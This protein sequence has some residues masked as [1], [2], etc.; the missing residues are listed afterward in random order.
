MKDGAA[1]AALAVLAS[2]PVVLR[3]LAHAL[4]DAT[5]PLDDGWSAQDVVAHL[6]DAETVAF[7]ERIR[8]IVGEDN[9]YINSIDPSRRLIEGGWS[10]RSLPELLDQFVEL[11]SANL[12]VAETL[13]PEQLARTGQHDEA[14]EITLQGI[15]HQWAYHDLMHLKQIASTL[16]APLVPHMGNTRRF[17]DL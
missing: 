11:R 10:G 16:Q 12:A 14:G 13:T 1:E 17:Y 6:V 2:T 8:R 3:S 5:E 15:I 7:A 9:P 4:E